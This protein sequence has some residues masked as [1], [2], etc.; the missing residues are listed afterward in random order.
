[1]D[2]QADSSMTSILRVGPAIEVV[3]LDAVRIQILGIGEAFTLADERGYIRDLLA[4]CDGTRSEDKVRALLIARLP[5]GNKLIDFLKARH[6][7][8]EGRDCEPSDPL[9]DYIASAARPFANLRDERRKQTSLKMILIRLVGN[10]ALADECRKALSALGL[11]FADKD[12]DLTLALYDVMNHASMRELNR[13]AF[14]TR[15][16]V[17]FASLD[18]FNIR[19]GPLVVP[20]ETACFECYHHR[21]RSQLQFR[22]EFDARTEGRHYIRSTSR[23]SG[24]ITR[25]AA[26]LVCTS[27]I[28][29]VFQH[30]SL[31]RPNFLVEQDLLSNSLFSHPILKL[32]RCPVCGPGRAESLQRDIYSPVTA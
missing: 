14:G 4:W 16:T 26:A 32:P 7:L 24:V 6:I 13:E 17:L 12:A 1:M 10:G 5:D 21:L 3:E 20:G 23:P 27:V 2:Q 30:R 11:N 18:R 15:D 19:V 22:R 8:V 28:G 25:A 9:V 29:F 31:G